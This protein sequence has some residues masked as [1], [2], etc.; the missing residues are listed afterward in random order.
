MWFALDMDLRRVK[1]DDKLDLSKK[2][3]YGIVLSR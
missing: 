1:N 3:F 2:Y